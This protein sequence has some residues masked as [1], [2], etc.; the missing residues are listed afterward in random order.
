MHWTVFETAEARSSPGVRLLERKSISFF[1]CKGPM[2]CTLN[3]TALSSFAEDTAPA[4][5]GDRPIMCAKSP[6]G[7]LNPFPVFTLEIS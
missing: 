3:T 6:T 1:V 5:S 4:E 7:T 2:R